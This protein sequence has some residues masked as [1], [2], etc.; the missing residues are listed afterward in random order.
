MAVE[1]CIILLRGEVKLDGNTGS[2]G[3]N[4]GLLKRKANKE[5]KK[6][7]NALMSYTGY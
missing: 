2:L 4:Q 3:G 7:T 5:G 1:R 6:G